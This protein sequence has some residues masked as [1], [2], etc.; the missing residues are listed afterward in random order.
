MGFGTS[1]GGVIKDPKPLTGLRADEFFSAEAAV[2]D[3]APV[4]FQEIKKYYK[5][6]AS[7]WSLYL[8]LRKIHRLYAQ[9]Y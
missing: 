6:D 2:P 4:D 7:I 1:A 9:E 5:E 8:N 3:M